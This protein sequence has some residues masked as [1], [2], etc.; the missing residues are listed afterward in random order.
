MK[1]LLSL[2]AALILSL[3]PVSARSKD[4]VHSAMHQVRIE[5]SGRCTAYATG[6][7]TI[8]IAEHCLGEDPPK[9]VFTFDPDTS[10]QQSATV[11]SETFD[12][13]D[14]VIVVLSGILFSEYVDVND[15]G[16][17]LQGDRVHFWG[18]AAAVGCSDCY[19]EGYYIGIGQIEDIDSALLL[20]D[21]NG[22]PGDSGSL[23]FDQNNRIVGMVSLAANHFVASF[24]L[25]FT[26]AEWKQAKR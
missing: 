20:F 7:H 13:A 11:V 12:H 10:F 2:L 21:L 22:A 14:H 25:L 5:H 24:P 1:I 8:M 19:R 17:P 23:I 18:A 6:P 3:S 15:R 9:D 4:Y 16:L 26:P